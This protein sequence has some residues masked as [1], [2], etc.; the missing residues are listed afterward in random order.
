M[1]RLLLALLAGLALASPAQARL[2]TQPELDA[3]VAPIALYPDGLIS[4]I[5]VASTYPDQVEAAARLPKDAPADESWN[6]SVQQ[7]V[8]FPDILQR[9]V[10]SPQWTRD[11]GEA[12][13]AQEPHVLD[14][15]QA[16]RRRAQAQGTLT[17]TEQQVVTQEGSAIVVQPRTEV[18]YAPYY[19]PYVVYGPWWWPAYRPVYWSPWVVAP[20]AVGFGFFYASPVWHHRH[21]VVVNKF[22]HGHGHVHAPRVHHTVV[23]SRDYHRVPESQRRPIVSSSP[24]VHRFDEH[25]GRGSSDRR[26]SGGEQRQRPE[27]RSAG[28]PEGRSA[29]QPE[30]RSQSPMPAAPRFSEQRSSNAVRALAQQQQRAPAQPQQQRAPAPQA[31]QRASAPPQPRVSAPQPQPRASAPQG[32]SGGEMRGNASRGGGFSAGHGGGN[33]SRSAG[34]GGGNRGGGGRG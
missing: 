34:G 4:D 13:L 22:V 25:R 1:R 29:G 17:S 19:D 12:F 15:V 23:R 24:Q 27:G 28:Q 30:R 20:V 7:L 26:W 6:P 2:F 9:M 32:R 14:T 10:E 5:L 33:G 16:L 3:L 11:L 18:V 21:V 8:S 31:P